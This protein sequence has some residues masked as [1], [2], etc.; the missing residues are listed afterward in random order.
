[1]TN[2]EVKTWADGLWEKAASKISKTAEQIGAKIPHQAIGD[3]YECTDNTAHWI[4]GFWPGIMWLMYDKTGDVKYSDIAKKCEERLDEALGPIGHSK[5]IAHDVG[6]A[7]SLASASSYKL[8]GDEMSKYRIMTAAHMLAGR[9]NIDGR[10]FRSWNDLP[11]VDSRGWTIADNM[12]NLPILYTA[13]E[14]LNDP[15]FSMMAQAHTETVIEKLVR[16]D[17]S[18]NHIIKLDIYTGE[19]LSD[20]EQMECIKYTQGAALDSSW[21]RGQAWVLYGLTLGYI[22]TQREDF[23]NA[24]KRCAHYFMAAMGERTVPPVDFRADEKSKGMDA[25]AGAIAAC[26]FIE[27]ANS[28]PESEKKMYFDF[29]VKLVKGL[30]EVCGDYSDKTDY[31]LKHAATHWHAKETRDCALIYA[32]YYYMEALYKLTGGKTLF[33]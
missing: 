10:F 22:H 6:F 28:V 12:M 8:T 3:K 31:L 27:I 24:A 32:D 19:K 23:L 2:T 9:F 18:A 11:E 1:M 20:E 17:G 25:S 29:G 21:T 16:P 30:D 4:T 14:I 13:S 7:W 26:A 15:R 5:S 33:W